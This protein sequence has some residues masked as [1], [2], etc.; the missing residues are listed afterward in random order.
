MLTTT[1][2]R[3]GASPRGS[4]RAAAGSIAPTCGAL[5]R[6]RNQQIRTFRFARIWASCLDPEPHREVFR[7]H[8]KLR[9]R[10]AETLNRR[11][12]WDNHPY[13]DDAKRTLKSSI[14]EC[15]RRD[16]RPT[17]RHVNTGARGRTP[18]NPT[19]V[20]PGRNIEDA[21][22][23]AMEH[24]LFGDRGAEEWPYAP[25][26]TR[27][28]ARNQQTPPT[29][30]A[31]V[32]AED[33]SSEVEY[34][35]DPITNRKVPKAAK[36][37]NVPD[38]PSPTINSGFNSTLHAPSDI[39]A[40]TFKGY[41]PQFT[42]FNPPPI[43]DSHDPVFYD[44]PPPEAELKKYGPVK[45]SPYAS[46]SAHSEQPNLVSESEEYE[47]NHAQSSKKSISWHS[48]DG[49]MATRNNASTDE[50]RGPNA[51]TAGSDNLGYKDLD[52]YVD[53]TPTHQRRY[54]DLEKYK[55]VVPEEE[56]HAETA[57]PQQ[58]Y[59]DLASY[60]TFTFPERDGR[61]ISQEQTVADLEAYEYQ[62]LASDQENARAVQ[63]DLPDHPSDLSDY[64]PF[65]YNEPDGRRASA[66]EEA[67][68]YDP[69]EVQQYQAFRYNEPD[70][71][72]AFASEEGNYD[73]SEVQSYQAFRHNEPDGKPLSAE[74]TEG[75][76][77]AELRECQETSLDGPPSQTPMADYAADASEL[78]QYGAVNHNEPDGKQTE[79]VDSTAQ[80]LG[81][82][83]REQSAG[84]RIPYLEPTEEER[85]EDLDLLRASDVRASFSMEPAAEPVENR[86]VLESEMARHAAASDVVD[87]EAAAAVKEAK[88]RSAEAVEKQGRR[89]TGNYM[90][91]FPEDFARSW[92]ESTFVPE[93]SKGAGA[94]LV[95][96]ALDR[97]PLQPALDRQA[98]LT[99]KPAVGDLFS[100][101]PQG[102]ETSYAKE[103]AS[104]P[105]SPVFVRRYGGQPESAAAANET[106]VL[107][108]SSQT[109][110]PADSQPESKLEQPTLYKILAYDQTMQTVT[111]AETTSHVSKAEPALTPAEVL[112]RL[113]NPAR[114][115]P[116]FGPLQAQG[117]EIV[118]GSGDV[119]VFR[120]V[121]GPED[122]S[123]AISAVEAEAEPAPAKEDTKAKVLPVNPI[124][125]T[126]S[127]P[128]RQ[129]PDPAIGR[130]A[131][132]TGFVNYDDVASAASGDA[133]GGARRS[134]VSG[135]D[136]RREEP[137]FS[138]ERKGAEESGGKER[139][140]AS[141]PKR[142][143]VGAAWL[144]GVSYALGVM[145]EY[146][147]T[148]GADGT[149]PK[150]F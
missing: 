103:R 71:K 150:G 105:D 21:E 47:N 123:A 119:L 43:S 147:K 87:E 10:F 134:F 23:G 97:Q 9:H 18:D 73:P 12:S 98:K 96:P 55:P 74:N 140:T 80:S 112:V 34:I 145:G 42:S 65:N 69:R 79:Q 41:E 106:G 32:L 121:R 54:D 101:E 139:T 131:S 138:G 60:N 109:A 86:D 56:V 148:G 44:G 29:R 25:P 122:S 67:S 127:K 143:A 49:I 38:V 78:R 1:A 62:Q 118:S 111:V 40:T 68:G 26:K 53:F 117:F 124:D 102:L 57:Q 59:P 45:L 130:F 104:T 90:R 13:A 100:A 8:R 2:I 48:N 85:A 94:P 77:A 115:F 51:W 11:L 88:R 58:P 82:F 107:P 93:Q 116:H 36:A 114:F 91:D 129:F 16:M 46:E 19:G 31:A 99:P 149:G 7:Y 76:T 136:V 28:R 113:S 89:L 15:W 22:R 83:D 146:F 137:V 108:S 95:Q 125:M 14:R 50:G 144:A 141:L 81:E 37:P 70:G 6:C 3:L 30:S 128:Q 27:G 61:P 20:R 126:G 64:T 4:R 24:L 132:P 142:M 66:A 133:G 39:P 84:Y 92:T 120:K 75:Y 17:G 63:E 52:K 135:I 110:T 5:L 33:P 72:P 35:I